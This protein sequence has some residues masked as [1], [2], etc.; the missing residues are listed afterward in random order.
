MD[1]YINDLTYIYKYWIA[2]FLDYCDS[3]LFPLSCQYGGKIIK[4]KF[5]TELNSV[6]RKI[7][8]IK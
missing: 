4:I 3:E 2:E 5:S 8:K 6:R 7:I 1:F